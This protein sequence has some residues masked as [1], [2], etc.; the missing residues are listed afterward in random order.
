MPNTT[1]AE[2]KQAGRA[3]GAFNRFIAKLPS[4]WKTRHLLVIIIAVLGTWAFL[5]SRSQW[6][7]MHRWNRAI[8]DM[9]LVLVAVSMAIG[10]L[11]RLF[12]SFRGAIPF[13]RELGIYGVILAIIH[14]III[15]D[16]WVMWDFARLFGFELHPQLQQYVMLKHGFGLANAVGIVALLYGLMLA[17]SSSN[18][19]QRKL[20]GS[21]W[22][23]LQQSAYV[24][25]MLI[26]LHTAYF[27]FMNFLD[28]HR[29]TPEPN[30]AQ[31]PF[32]ALVAGIIFLQS[33]A[34]IK[35]WS[36]RRNREQSGRRQPDSV[37]QQPY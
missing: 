31:W 35:T 24:L 1:Y 11:S 15:L 29:S 21:A 30:W 20:G 28:Y 9:S 6:S 37:D 23:F 22:K 4:G 14:T 13:R 17:L 12:S 26:V 5:E 33:A 19:S 25:W 16:G 3:A 32:V 34:Y 7:P 18:W 10:P 27:L 8:G 36:L 2:T